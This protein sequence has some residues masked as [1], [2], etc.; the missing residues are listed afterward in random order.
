M[1]RAHVS[2]M[3]NKKFN[4]TRRLYT[5]AITFLFMLSGCSSQ[6]IHLEAL[7]IDGIA[8]VGAITAQPAGL[9]ETTNLTLQK[10][11]QFAS[12][13]GGLCSAKV[14][15]VTSP[16]PIYR[17]YDATQ[18]HTKFG[19]WWTFKPPSGAKESYRAANAIC[20]E[21]SRLDRMLSCELKIGTEIVIGTTQS[22]VCKKDLALPKT[23]ENQVFVPKNTSMNHVHIEKCEEADIWH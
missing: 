14:F 15:L 19:E 8:C 16:I 21:W 20:Q 6:P 7:G 18:A 4:I 23:A 17:V 22:A 13:K 1:N 10:K 5:A 2:H 9:I 12:E 3:S 11:A